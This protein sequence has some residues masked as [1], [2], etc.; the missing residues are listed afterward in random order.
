MWVVKLEKAPKP[1]FWQNDYFPRQFHYKA[2]AV[3]LMKLVEKSGGK[4]VVEKVKR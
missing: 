1:F 2:D 3:Q 4:A